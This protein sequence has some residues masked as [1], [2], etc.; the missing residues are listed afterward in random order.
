MR[1]LISDS[2][3]NIY[4]FLHLQVEGV[5]R[6][7]R[8]LPSPLS[9]D[10]NSVASN[11]QSE[12][13]PTFKSRGSRRREEIPEKDVFRS[14]TRSRPTEG[15]S[16]A[17]PPQ[18][19]NERFDSR[20]TSSRYRSRPAEDE[21]K[22][23]PTVF[24]ENIVRSK[25]RQVS[26][27]P[28]QTTEAPLEISSTAIDE[29]K[30]EIINSNFNDIS[31]IVPKED[32][33][34]TTQFRRRS[35]SAPIS[36]STTESINSKRSR[37]RINTRTNIQTPDLTSSGTTN[38]ISV[39][40]K[41]PTT[42]R[43]GDLRNSRKLRDRTRQSETDTNLTGEGLTG[44]NEVVKSSQSRKKTSQPETQTFAPIVERLVSQSTEANRLKTTTLK[45]T[46]VI[47]RP[48]G[49][50]KVSKQIDSKSQT[51]EEIN[52]DD[53]YPPSFKALIQAKNASVSYDIPVNSIEKKL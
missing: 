3:F 8:R 32:N 20:R 33:I 49:R 12:V 52:E 41:E 43:T 48:L 47:R 25:T 1:C 51:T 6:V 44:S 26:R 18:G 10:D 9:P 28:A 30:I 40:D 50:V 19:S 16:E 17:P 7:G 29:S 15:I 42:A 34:I 45:V 4:I 35:S 11:S 22:T 23:E 39:S 2:I 38:S 21:I 36:T 14:R 24:K 53:N 37:G 13:Q 5:S 46:K 27:R 31:K